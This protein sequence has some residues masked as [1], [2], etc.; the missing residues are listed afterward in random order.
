MRLAAPNHFQIIRGQGLT[1][2]PR[3]DQKLIAYLLKN[4]GLGKGM[5]ADIAIK[6]YTIEIQTEA[7]GGRV[8]QSNCKFLPKTRSTLTS[9]FFA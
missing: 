1:I 8:L 2:D 5:A 3:V 4:I 6:L 7:I 9:S